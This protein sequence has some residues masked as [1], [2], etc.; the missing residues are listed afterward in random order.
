MS[1]NQR[2]QY[3]ARTSYPD[4]GRYLVAVSGGLDST[5]LLDWLVAGGPERELVVAHFDHRLRANSGDDAKFVTRLAESYG[6]DCQIGVGDLS[7]SA[8]EAEA[9]S[10]RYRFLAQSL[11]ATKAGA[12]ITAH[13]Q[14]DLIETMILNLIR[15]TGRRGLTSLR[16]QPRLQRPF[17]GLPKS[18]LLAEAEARGLSWV[19]DA[20][21]L[22]P[23]LRRNWVR[24]TIC[25]RLD[26]SSRRQLLEIQDRMS[27]LNDR[28]DRQLAEYLKYVSYRRQGQV[29]PRDW[30]NQLPDQLATEVVHY[31]LASQIG[32]SG[33]GRQIRY[34]VDQLRQLAPG[35]RLS[36]TS[37]QFIDLT[38]RSIRL[39]QPAGNQPSR[40]DPLLALADPSPVSS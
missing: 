26:D 39:N 3:L 37:G 21:N 38:K 25:P 1:L 14:D 31:W 28:F 11:E 15:G 4:P 5:V 16:S 7:P 8:G 20:T 6:L 27:E 2:H 18:A 13:H 10:A 17:L 12:V 23:K 19:E 36:L 9:R 40:A 35:K 29:Y 32:V 34:L 33:R 30:F 24:Q 22:S